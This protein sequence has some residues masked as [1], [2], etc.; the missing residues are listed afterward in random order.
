MIASFEA[1]LEPS[2]KSTWVVQNRQTGTPPSH[3]VFHDDRFKA[4]APEARPSLPLIN[5]PLRCPRS[6]NNNFQTTLAGCNFKCTSQFLVGVMCAKP[7]RGPSGFGVDSALDFRSFRSNFPCSDGW[8]K[9][10]YSAK[11]AL[12]VCVFS[13]V[14]A[15]LLI[16]TGSVGRSVRSRSRRNSLF[17]PKPKLEKRTR[18]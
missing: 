3:S 8:M 16:F 12:F 4:A 15:L 18:P 10:R 5:F 2:I 11:W 9:S 7:T 14:S 13:F 6:R 1:N 17:L